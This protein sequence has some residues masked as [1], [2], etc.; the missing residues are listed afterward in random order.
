MV[1]LEEQ[2]FNKHNFSPEKYIIPEIKK[3]EN[4]FPKTSNYIVKEMMVSIKISKKLCEFCKINKVKRL[5]YKFCCPECYNEHKKSKNPKYKNQETRYCVICQKQLI[6]NEKLCSRSCLGKY[7][8]SQK[9]INTIKDRNCSFCNILFK[10]KHNSTRFCSKKCVNE[11]AK[12]DPKRKE[13][14]RKGGRISAQKQQ[15]RSKNEIY[16][17]ELCEKQFGFLNVLTNDPMFD[18]WDADIILPDHKIAIL[19]NGIWHYQK[20]TEKHS[21]LQ[22]Q[23]RDKYKLKIIAKY[24]Y[25]PYIIKDMGKYN[26]KFVEEQFEIFKQT[27][28]STD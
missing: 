28:I 27:L 13:I 12:I 2:I 25:N 22:V 14:G 19:W 6:R 16:F 10:P 8:N 21:L 17:A 7:A 24:G 20:I 3:C 1:I 15:R 26:P 18:G 11:S 9:N 23:S 5:Y 4:I